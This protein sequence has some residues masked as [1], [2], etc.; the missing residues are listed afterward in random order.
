MRVD[1]L[2][3]TRDWRRTGPTG[4]EVEFELMDGL[5]ASG[6]DGA[7]VPAAVYARLGERVAAEG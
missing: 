1:C 5:R 6:E 7:V 3:E 2:L 4:L